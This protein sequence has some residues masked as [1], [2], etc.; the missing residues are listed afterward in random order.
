M[1]PALFLIA[2][3]T[4]SAW[5]QAPSDDETEAARATESL[6]V[7]RK[8]A[9]SYVVVEER[10]VGKVTLEF[11]PEPLLQWS[12][13]VGGSFHGAVFIWT[14]DGRPD[15]IASIYRKYVPTPPHLGIEFHSLTNAQVSAGRDGHPEWFPAS[16]IA[17]PEPVADA[18]TPADSD[19]QR[20]RQLRALAREFTA[21]K[22]DRKDV[23]RPLR[24]LTQPIYRYQSASQ[25]V[26]DGALFAFVEGTD[27]EVFL[28]IEARRTEGK[29]DSVWHYALARMNS[30]NFRVSHKA[31]EVW[32]VPTIPWPQAHN[33]REPYTLFTFRPGEGV[34]PPDDSAEPT[35][36][37]PN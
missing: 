11:H 10:P 13:P 25:G 1:Q 22:T 35:S 18:A 29:K 16:G 30:V 12:N 27:P 6:P 7:V 2:L 5:A 3:S 9:E 20:L 17:A 31:R 32:S 37:R 28:L 36:V 33:P 34:N 14:A 23:T 15:V 21:T 24:L 26:V 19:A 4:T 8:A